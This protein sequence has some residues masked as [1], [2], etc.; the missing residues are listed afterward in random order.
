[1][2]NYSQDEKIEI[3]KERLNHLLNNSDL[4]VSIL[5][6]ILDKYV[7]DLSK[8]YDN[9]SMRVREGIVEKQKNQTENNEDKAD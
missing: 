2:I 8:V 4:S 9:Y 6:P 1:M 5:Y 3:F 7:Q